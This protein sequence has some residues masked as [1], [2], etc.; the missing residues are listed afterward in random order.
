MQKISFLTLLIASLL[1]TA[2]GLP[3]YK[4]ELTETGKNVELVNQ[5]ASQ[6][7][8]IEDFYTYMTTYQTDESFQH[9]VEVQSRNLAGQTP[10]VDTI[11]I[12][13]ENNLSYENSY[14]INS[15]QCK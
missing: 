12:V 14:V 5:P 6:C 7:R 11:E 2:C 13:S 9:N 1:L 15:Y 4:M 10:G 3:S 8:F